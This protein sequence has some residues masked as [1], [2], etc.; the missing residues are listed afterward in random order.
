MILIAEHLPI[1]YQR[2]YASEILTKL[3][4]VIK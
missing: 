4:C 3:L 2:D 1:K